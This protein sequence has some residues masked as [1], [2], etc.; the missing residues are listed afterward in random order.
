[1]RIAGYCILVA[2]RLA[3]L[4]VSPVYSVRTFVSFGRSLTL[5]CD[6][7]PAGMWI[8]CFNRMS[9]LIGFLWPNSTPEPFPLET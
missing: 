3:Q 8:G 9:F 2:L 4:A 1:M 5:P 7:A 6:G